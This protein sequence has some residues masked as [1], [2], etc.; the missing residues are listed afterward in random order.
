LNN[1]EAL[2]DA[3][4]KGERV[5]SRRLAA[6][7]GIPE[8][9]A[10]RQ[11]LTRLAGPRGLAALLAERAALRLRDT[12]RREQKQQDKAAQLALRE[13]QRQPAADAWCAWFDGS[14]HPNPGRIGIGAVLRGPAGQRLEISR[15]EGH[16]NSGEA[17]YLAL[18]ALL[19]AAVPM[20]PPSLVVY[21]DSQVVINDV[22]QGQAGAKGLE[23]HRARVA[24]LLA[25]LADVS[26]RWIPRHRNGAADQLS[27]RAAAGTHPDDDDAG[28]GG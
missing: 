22:N 7:N 1:D 23:G 5:A 3:A 24:G 25:Q 10:L 9:E 2:V 14:A 26:L 21:G 17:E 6:R 11:T 28:R 19:E 8:M 20:H 12:A 16:G 15:R 18:I 13:A 27:Q 4:Y